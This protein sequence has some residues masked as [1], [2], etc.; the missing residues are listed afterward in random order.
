MDKNT[1]ETVGNRVRRYMLG[2]S[3]RADVLELLDLLKIAGVSLGGRICFRYQVTVGQ[4]V[5]TK[6]YDVCCPMCR[7][8]TIYF[9]AD[10]GPGCSGMDGGCGYKVPKEKRPWYDPPSNDPNRGTAPQGPRKK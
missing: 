2:K 6:R 1:A 8:P 3:S 10:F 7:K 4:D 5:I 9:F